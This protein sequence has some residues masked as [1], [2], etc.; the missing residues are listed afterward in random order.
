MQRRQ[1]EMKGWAK[2]LTANKQCEIKIRAVGLHIEVTKWLEKQLPHMKGLQDL[3]A[4]QTFQNVHPRRIELACNFA[5]NFFEQLEKYKTS[6]KLIRLIRDH[7]SGFGPK[8]R[9]GSNLLINM[10]NERS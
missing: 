7:C 8:P 1:Q 2:D 10:F 4:L 5:V 9:L 6:Q 3:S